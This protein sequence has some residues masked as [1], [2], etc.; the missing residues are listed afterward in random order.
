MARP[1][2]EHVLLFVEAQ[3]TISSRRASSNV[4]RAASV[5]SSARFEKEAVAGEPQRELAGE[6]IEVLV[7]ATQ[8]PA[9]LPV[10]GEIHLRPA[11]AGRC[12][13]VQM[14]VPNEHAHLCAPRPH[15]DLPRLQLQRQLFRAQ[16][17]AD[18]RAI[19]LRPHASRADD[20]SLRVDV[21]PERIVPAIRRARRRSGSPR[22]DARSAAAAPI[23]A[24]ARSRVSLH[25]W[26][27]FAGQVA[28]VSLVEIVLVEI[29]W[30]DVTG[31]DGGDASRSSL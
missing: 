3:L 15:V 7:L 18:D 29:V 16:V 10:R 13:R 23:S 14:H 12:C 27:R 6:A 24:S 20:P 4:P 22:R 31:R 5:Y 8:H 28:R 21:A 17:R 19:E 9:H 2:V 26:G 1:F 25:R 30:R 11:P